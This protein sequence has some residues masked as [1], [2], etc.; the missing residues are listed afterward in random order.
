M[1]ERNR[2]FLLIVIMIAICSC[3][4]GISMWFLYKTALDEERGRLAETVQSQAQSIE[5][6]KRFDETYK[7][8]FSE[9]PVAATLEQIKDAHKHYKGFGKTGEFT[10][11]VKKEDS[12]VFLLS[13]RHYDL[14]NPKPVPFDSK[15]AEPMRMALSGKSGTLIGLDYRGE[16]VLSAYEP[17]K[18]LGLGIVAK[19]DMDEIKAPFVHT[20][21]V[22][23]SVTILLILL[24][25][26]LF[27]KISNPIVR[28]LEDQNKDLN[29]KIKEL[30][31]TKAKLLDSNEKL[32]AL[33]H[34]S[35]LAIVAIDP[36]GNIMLWNP[37]AEKMFGWKE[38]E[39]MGR[40]L[41]FVSEEKEGEHHAL[42]K[43]VLSGEGFDNVEVWRRR[44]DGSNIYVSISTALLRDSAGRISGI[45]SVVADV[46]AR[47]KAEDALRENEKI[48]QLFIEHA[49]AAL[50]MFDRK[51][52]YLAVSRRWMTDYNLG[53]R[54]IIGRSHYDIFPKIPDRWKAVHRRGL[55][56]EI[57]KEDEDSFLRR[58]GT[59]IWQRWE[60][61]P[62]YKVG[63]TIGGIVIFTEDITDHK[64]AEEEIKK[65]SEQR[66]MLSAHLQETIER[67]RIS[68]AREIH[69]D[70]GQTLSAL[71]MDI[72]WIKKRLLSDQQAMAEKMNTM[73]ALIN[74]SI[75]TVKQICT[76]LRPGVL[77]DLGLIYTMEWY[78]AQ[79]QARTGVQCRLT[80]NPAKLEVS[81]DMA[82]T[83]YRIFQE[84]LTNVSRHAEAT[85]VEASI[86]HKNNKILIEINDNGKG[87]RGSEMSR[88]TSFGI[89][90]MRERVYAL[91]GEFVITGERDK[92]TRINATIPLRNRV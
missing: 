53:D 47:R 2:F 20:A 46:T 22:V 19:I 60:V 13:H 83:I 57:V 16:K 38:K 67:E 52:R 64:V 81:D 85:R 25:A 14:N 15:L 44:K 66:R 88:S 1:D 48:L 24:G 63:G 11:G 80:V 71:K 77:D 73:T 5:S 34:S 35:P 54:A 56:G 75:Q 12:I 27:L 65:V 61:R 89:V 43:R 17:V 6:I 23:V 39:V 32:N 69:D 4:T 74:R 50:A 37:A 26:A 36:E 87:I 3:V 42:R 76:E 84:A 8:G 92:G 40:F 58:D 7:K 41:P 45:M 9:G 91:G 86:Q 21:K 62:W 33:I 78:S 10:L 72:G 30:K 28:Q 90:G 18:G 31:E 68:I 51:M 55:E 59:L 79:F 70:L 82:T 49:P 29:K